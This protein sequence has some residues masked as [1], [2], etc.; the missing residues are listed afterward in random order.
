MS[1]VRNLLV[2]ASESQW[3]RER[4]PRLGFVRRGAARFLPGDDADAAVAAA[5]R[6]AADGLSTLFTHLGENVR[7]RAEAEAVTQ[8]YLDLIDRIRAE[9]LSAEISVKLTQLG[10]DL[11]RGLCLTNLV[12]LLDYSV[13]R[14]VW[15]D[16]E[17]SLYLDATL[18]LH[19]RAHKV[20]PHVGVCV[21]A[22]LYRT[23]KDVESLIS[24]GAAVRL[25]KGAYN[26][27]R[28]IAFPRKANVDE[29]YFRL[30]QML[31][32]TEARRAGT[33]AVIATHDPRLIARISDWAAHEGLAREQLE[34]AMLYGI[35][36][37]QQLQL[38]REGYRS[39]V[40][41]SYGTFWFPWFMRR[42]A[43]RPANVFF[44]ARNL[45]SR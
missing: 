39:D 23:A 1:W 13:G 14:T 6:L 4:A 3:L 41:I 32:G 9:S 45:F 26:E 33:R 44:L 11:D 17:Q 10:L 16:M 22:Y 25:V 42:L 24:M 37:A 2:E 30:A 18:E 28:E 19:A 21:Q 15:I 27:P 35:A 20:H 34:F 8:G 29:N 7:D 40:L 38:A 31:L 43:E 36:R 12:K 5:R